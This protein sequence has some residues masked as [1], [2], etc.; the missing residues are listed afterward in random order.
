MGQIS[1]DFLFLCL[2][3][4]VSL[5]LTPRQLIAS[6]LPELIFA[7]R[8]VVPP[9]L[10]ETLFHIQERAFVAR[11]LGE[12]DA[13]EDAHDDFGRR[14]YPFTGQQGFDQSSTRVFAQQELVL[15][16]ERRRVD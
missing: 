10:P 14:R 16:S 12:L 11:R 7:E 2:Y 5:W 1:S 6:N 9:E 13:F 8:E 3:V 15:A 4:S